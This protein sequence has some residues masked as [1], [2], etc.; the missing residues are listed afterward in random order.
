[1]WPI[2]IN[3]NKVA[4]KGNKCFFVLLHEDTLRMLEGRYVRIEWRFVINV[5]NMFVL[6]VLKPY[7]H[8]GRSRWLRGL[9][10]ESAAIRLLGLWVR[11]PRGTW[12]SFC[13]QCFVLSGR[14]LCVGL[15]TRPEET[16]RVC[17]CVCVIECY[18]E[19][20]IMRRPLPT[21]GCCNT[22]KKYIYIY[23]YSERHAAGKVGQYSLQ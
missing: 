19:A 5:I 1:M 15:I 16:Y 13:C 2:N 8:S 11:I 3:I 21:R 14:G 18:R 12:M 10:H 17:V 23:I 20:S 7:V 4:L 22:G 6:V 9:R